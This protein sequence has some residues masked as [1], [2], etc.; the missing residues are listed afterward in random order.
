MPVAHHGTAQQLQSNQGIPLAPATASSTTF[1]ILPT[2]V[3]RHPSAPSQQ[4]IYH[5]HDVVSTTKR[6]RVDST[7]QQQQ[8]MGVPTISGEQLAAAAAQAMQQ[9]GRG[10]KKSQAQIDRRRERNRILARRTRLRKKFFFE[11]LQKEVLDLRQENTRLK[12]LVKA[13][14]DSEASQTI[15]S[16]CDAME[17]LPESVLEACGT[18][19]SMASEDFNLV[20]SIQMSQHSFII[21]DPSLNDNPIVFASNDFLKLTGYT[22]EQ[23]LGRNCR[24][25]QG[26]ETSKEKLD[27]IRK[28]LA[29]GEDVTVTMINYMADGTPFWNKL[30]IASLRDAQNNVVNYIGVTVRVAQPLPGDPEHGKKLPEVKSQA[31]AVAGGSDADDTVRAIEG[32]VTAA[33]AASGGVH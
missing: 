13:N 22:R 17:K 20:N 33:V 19:Q 28:S 29:S 14:L 30:F 11:S 32:A 26:E 16:E 8:Q 10:R 31:G 24:F 12:E 9:Q 2:A 21:T 23:V 4:L 6:R 27:I 3:P 1:P 18:D 25:L 7:Q 5:Q 15:L